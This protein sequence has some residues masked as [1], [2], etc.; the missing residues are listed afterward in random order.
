MS[1]GVVPRRTPG[2]RGR[3][4]APAPRTS[5]D[6][7]ICRVRGDTGRTDAEGTR[8]RNGASERAE[9]QGGRTVEEGLHLVRA[10]GARAG[11]HAPRHRLL[12]ISRREGTRRSPRTLHRRR[13]ARR[14]LAHPWRARGHVVNSF[15]NW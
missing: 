2:A 14:L 5:A 11:A 15:K 10:A 8:T 6:A 4:G 7:P 1:P 9:G 13:A 12:R 3:N